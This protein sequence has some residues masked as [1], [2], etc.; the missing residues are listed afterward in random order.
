M[1]VPSYES[2]RRE[3]HTVE[4]TEDVFKAG[5]DYEFVVLG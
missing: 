2:C 5:I 3:R 1:G 4:D